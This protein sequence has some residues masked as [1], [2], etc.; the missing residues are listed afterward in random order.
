MIKVTTIRSSRTI[1]GPKF[2][3]HAIIAHAWLL[4]VPTIIVLPSCLHH[5]SGIMHL[6]SRRSRPAGPPRTPARLSPSR[7]KALSHCR[8]RVP[9]S[10]NFSCE[11]RS[12]GPQSWSPIRQLVPDAFTEAGSLT[13][14]RRQF[15]VFYGSP[16]P[17]T[18][19]RHGTQLHS[20][21]LNANY[22]FLFIA[23]GAP[24]G[25]PCSFAEFPLIA[26]G[27]HNLGM[28]TIDEQEI[29]EMGGWAPD[30]L[31]PAH[32]NDVAVNFVESRRRFPTLNDT[33]VGKGLD[34]TD[35]FEMANRQR[36]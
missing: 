26:P 9:S 33:A 23:S 20:A 27:G 14:D 15:K 25:V 13:D 19:T 32:V 36:P 2:G 3:N 4:V 5:T 28:W 11:S 8:G 7:N 6:G 17:A 35:M 34:I 31:R 29:R 10:A 18:K 30:V 12:R 22:R 21:L 24:L 16:Y 1:S